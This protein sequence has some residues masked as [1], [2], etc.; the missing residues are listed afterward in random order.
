MAFPTSV[1]V[2]PGWLS[3][4][5]ARH[6]GQ[7]SRR[8]QVCALGR[9]CCGSLACHGVFACHIRSITWSPS[10]KGNTMH[11][12]TSEVTDDATKLRPQYALCRPTGRIQ[13]GPEQM[14]A[15]LVVACGADTVDKAL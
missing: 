14:Q 13:V 9:I 10:S 5:M 6:A 11:T 8:S 12:S 7:Q 4:A 1:Q 3:T 15:A 2:L